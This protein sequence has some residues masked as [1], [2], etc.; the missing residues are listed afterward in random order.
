MEDHLRYL[1]LVLERLE[2]H[3]LKISPE[4]CQI[5]QQDL[6]D[7]LG[8][9]VHESLIE[10]QTKHL[11]QIRVFAVPRIKKQL[12]RFFGCLRLVSRARAS[13]FGID[14]RHD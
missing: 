2:L 3:S 6:L 5:A 4:K 13:L 12:Q 9:R 14:C 8:L 7:Y 11:E 10:P 1:R